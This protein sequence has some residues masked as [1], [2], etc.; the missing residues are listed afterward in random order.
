MAGQKGGGLVGGQ[1]L[2][3]LVLSLEVLPFTLPDP[4]LA[5]PV[6]HNSRWTSEGRRAP[7][8]F[9]REARTGRVIAR[10]T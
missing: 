4:L 8:W 2:A 1:H 6:P 7:S 3:E 9:A 10:A 5:L